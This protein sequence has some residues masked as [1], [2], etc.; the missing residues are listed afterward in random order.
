MMIFC[1]AVVLLGFSGQAMAGGG[2]NYPN[3]S[4][5]FLAGAAPPPGF[6][7]LDYAFFYNADTMKDDNGDNVEAFDD[8]SVW[9]NVFRFL[10]IPICRDAIWYS[11]PIPRKSWES[12]GGSPTTGRKDG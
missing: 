3:G 9:A 7:F 6:Y 5:A 11:S 1:L 8:I 2:Q 10:W 12:P 4:E